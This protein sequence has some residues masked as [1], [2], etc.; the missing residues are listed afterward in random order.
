MTNMDLVQLTQQTRKLSAMVVEDEK[1][2]NELL[3]SN[4][5][6]FFGEVRSYL[7]GVDALAAYTDFAPD[8]VFVDIMM[9]KMNT[10]SYRVSIKI[11]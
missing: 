2:S 11:K 7:N 3:S 9:D 5:K 4:L 1:V 10:S 8:I 6:T